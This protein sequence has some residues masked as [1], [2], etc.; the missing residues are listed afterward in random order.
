MRETK[1]LW[2]IFVFA[3]AGFLFAGYLT[4][5]KLLLGYCPLKEPC[6]VIFGQP[7][8][9][10]GLVLF[11]IILLSTIFLLFCKK[12]FV[13]SHNFL[14]E[15]VF[16]VSFFGILFALYSTYLELFAVKCPG[17]CQYSLLIPTC[18][19]GLIFY[20]FIFIFSTKLK[21]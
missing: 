6:P 1:S 7:A 18:I 15:I 3:I 10:Y 19:Y 9:V 17:G 2:T 13:H 14:K 11:T 8:C 16:W 5:T 21:K 20:M 12:S 4:F